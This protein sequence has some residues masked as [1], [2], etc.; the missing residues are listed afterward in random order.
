MVKTG[1]NSWEKFVWLYPVCDKGV[2]KHRLDASLL[3]PL[4]AGLLLR[5]NVGVHAKA[6]SPTLEEAVRC[7]TF[8]TASNC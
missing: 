6:L 2:P 3:G 1:Y 4:T 7:T 8:W 5:L